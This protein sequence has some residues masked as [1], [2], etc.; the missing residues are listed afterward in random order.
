VYAR[1]VPDGAGGTRELTFGVSGFLIMNAL[2][3][4]DRETDTLWSQFSGQA[5][6]GELAGTKLRPSGVTLTTWET[7]RETHPDTT[8]LD[9]G[10]VARDPYM[11]YYAENTAGTLGETNVDTRLERKEFVLGIHRDDGYAKAYPFRHL[12][13]APVLNDEAPGLPFVVA[14]DAERGVGQ[15]FDRTVDGRVLSFEAGP[16]TAVGGL[17]LR[18][19]ETGSLWSPITGEALEGP[20]LGSTLELVPSFAV[21]WFAWTDFHPDTEF[22]EPAA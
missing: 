11:F 6:R 14:F 7:W 16:L 19:S 8:A 21:F 18:D 15:I 17:T 13:G 9:Q 20:L 10:G 5:V 12:S 22:Y 2:V 3:M 4:Y 1:E